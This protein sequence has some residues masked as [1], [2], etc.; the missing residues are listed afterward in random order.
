MCQDCSYRESEFPF[1][2]NFRET[3]I[4]KLI[5]HDQ[6][7]TLTTYKPKAVT[8]K[9]P[10]MLGW[11]ETSPNI[12]LVTHGD[13]ILHLIWKMF[14]SI[15][16]DDAIGVCKEFK[17]ECNMKQCSLSLNLFNQSWRLLNKSISSA[18]E[19]VVLDFLDIYQICKWC[20]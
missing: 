12:G 16:I 15:L 5:S 2:P 17:C 9:K 14:N 20:Q 4:N 6:K 3:R 11:K 13:G 10:G 19:K 7:K 8:E 18:V 1:I